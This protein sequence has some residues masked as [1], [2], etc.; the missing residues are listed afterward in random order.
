VTKQSDNALSS[1][2]SV[3]RPRL[4]FQAIA[5]YTLAMQKICHRYRQLIQPSCYGAFNREK[6]V[7]SAK[8]HRHTPKYVRRVLT[9]AAPLKAV[10]I[11]SLI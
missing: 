1:V 6:V 11:S 10:V 5:H 7:A 4:A 2:P 8:Q 9:S 3:K